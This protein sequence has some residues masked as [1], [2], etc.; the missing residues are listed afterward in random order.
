MVRETPRKSPSATSR[1][2]AESLTE[3]VDRLADV[4]ERSDTP[5]EID[6]L[7]TF[8]T[9]GKIIGRKPDSVS[10]FCKDA[11]VPVYY[12]FRQGFVPLVDLANA[13]RQNTEP[14]SR[15]DAMSREAIEANA[16]TC[17]SEAALAAAK[18]G[19]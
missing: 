15:P 9:V 19:E 13:I 17:N 16:K 14:Q 1:A 10:R 12:A 3:A 7:A 2:V 4:F 5:R 8:E 6:G 18:G 11:G